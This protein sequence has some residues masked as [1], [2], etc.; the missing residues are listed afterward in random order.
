MHKPTILWCVCVCVGVSNAPKESEED[1]ETPQ[2]FKSIEGPMPPW[3]KEEESPRWSPNGQRAAYPR[4]FILASTKSRAPRCPRTA[5]HPAN[6]PEHC[7]TTSAKGPHVATQP[8]TKR[9]LHAYTPHMYSTH[10]HTKPTTHTKTHTPSTPPPHQAYN[11]GHPVTSHCFIFVI[12]MDSMTALGNN[13]V[14]CGMLLVTKCLKRQ[15]N[16][17]CVDTI[18]EC[19]SYA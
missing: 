2:E 15:C 17:V 6:R 12:F 19:L 1:R 5:R 10:P 7:W 16:V 8:E 14:F 3:Q 4:L 18:L 9:Y 13:Y 11:H